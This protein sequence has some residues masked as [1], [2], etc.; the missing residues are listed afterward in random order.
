MQSR[1]TRVYPYTW[2]VHV[3]LP[4]TKIVPYLCWPG[5]CVFPHLL[6][7]LHAAFHPVVMRSLLT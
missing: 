3:W 7:L 2:V 1:T 5:G 4:C 6:V